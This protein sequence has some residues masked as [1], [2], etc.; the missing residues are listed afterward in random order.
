MG[1][2]YNFARCLI[3]LAHSKKIEDNEIRERDTTNTI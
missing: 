1:E 3:G 2:I